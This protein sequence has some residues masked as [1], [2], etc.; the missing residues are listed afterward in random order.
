MID[1]TGN[2]G[3][4]PAPQNLD[5]ESPEYIKGQ[6]EKSFQVAAHNLKDRNR[7]RHPTKRNVKLMDAY[8]LLP[9]HDAF[10]DAGGYFTIK[11]LTNP[12]P[13]S[14]TYDI[15]LENGLLKPIPDGEEEVAA[16][17]AASELHEKDPERYPAPDDSMNYEFYLTESPSDA[18][19]FKRK[20]DVL[21]PEKDDDELYT[22]KNTA[23]ESNFRLGRIRAYESASQVGTKAD[24]YEEEVV[25]A[26]HDGHDG[27]HQKGAYYY[28]LVQKLSIRPQRAKNIFN[29]KRGLGNQED[30]AREVADFI[31]VQIEDPNEV[32]K[33]YMDRYKEEPTWMPEDEDQDDGQDGEQGERDGS[34]TPLQQPKSEYDEG[35]NRVIPSTEFD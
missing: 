5:R 24:K 20:L 28:P 33:T 17:K 19:N 22:N 34:A 30:E 29:S 26:L 12:V 35:G 23:G 7:V 27:F 4:R 18:S 32:A 2:R 8:P 16:K 6:I 1:N 31:D 14:S 13:P 10:P 9:D 3:K 21:D 15:R 11:F 25:I